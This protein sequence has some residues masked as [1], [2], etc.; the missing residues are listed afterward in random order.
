MQ[1][2][3]LVFSSLLAL[4]LLGCASDGGDQTAAAETAKAAN[5]EQQAMV[6][7]RTCPDMSQPMACTMEYMPY[8]GY[9]KDNKPVK[10]VQGS[11]CNVCAV[12][13]VVSYA[14]DACPNMP[15]E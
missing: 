14:R 8:C 15:V 3:K 12:P 11:M 1:L 7:T 9:D 2:K 4:T 6:E 10:T 13:G 5:T